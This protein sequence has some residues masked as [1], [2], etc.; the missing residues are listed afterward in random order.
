MSLRVANE[1]AKRRFGSAAR[2]QIIM[3]L[4]DKATD[5]AQASGVPTTRSS[6]TPSWA[7]VP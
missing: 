1:C 4:A 5:D 3:F 7:K 2:K 6:A